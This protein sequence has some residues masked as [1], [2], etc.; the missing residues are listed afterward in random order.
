MIGALEVRSGS[1]LR[2]DGELWAVIER[3]HHKPGK[4]GAIVR[5]K[6]RRLATGAVVEKTFRASEKFDDVRLDRAKMQYLYES[7]GEFHFMNT[8]SY[9]QVVFDS[10]FL[11]D[12]REYL[13]ENMEIDVLLHDG[14]PVV[15]EMPMFVAL[16][17]VR[18]DPGIRGDTASG[19]T[20]PATLESGAV[21]QVP[22]FVQEGEVIKVDTRDGSYVERVS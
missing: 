11:G 12:G 19:G 20:K 10:D 2:L 5:L 7:G 13:K 3:H 21:V 22:L 8:E 18:T 17:I 1:V 16:R 6:V 4:G 15:C 9:E 14:R